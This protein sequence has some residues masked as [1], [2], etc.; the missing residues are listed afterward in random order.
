MNANPSPALSVIATLGLIEVTSD[1]QLRNGTR[2][3]Y[4]PEARAYYGS[5]AAG[6]ARRLY[7]SPFYGKKREMMMYPLN[8]REIKTRSFA[9]SFWDYATGTRVPTGEIVD[10]KLKGY[11]LIEDPV[12]RLELIASAA[13]RYRRTLSRWN[14]ASVYPNWHPL[15]RSSE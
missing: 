12:K 5:Y 2:M 3:F 14:K 7:S 9:A 6:Y 8:P 13:T 1:K 11:K 4:D 15:S 10:C